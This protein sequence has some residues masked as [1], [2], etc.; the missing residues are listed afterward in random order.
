VS[1][2]EKYAQIPGLDSREVRKKVRGP[3]KRR[4]PDTGARECR[5]LP[6]YNR[7][8]AMPRCEHVCESS[9]LFAP[10]GSMRAPVD[11]KFRQAHAQSR[12][13]GGARGF[14]HQCASCHATPVEQRDLDPKKDL[15]LTPQFIVSVARGYDVLKVRSLTDLCGLRVKVET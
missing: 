10:A 9:H 3:D 8:P 15:P 6:G 5:R 7:G 11:E 1:G 12:D 14:A 4:D 2:V 13:S